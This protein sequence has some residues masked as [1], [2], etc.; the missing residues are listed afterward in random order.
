MTIK[1]F[2]KSKHYSTIP[3]PELEI[4]PMTQFIKDQDKTDLIGVEIGTLHGYNARNIL[5]NLSIKKLYL[6]DPYELYPEYLDITSPFA[7]WAGKVSE[8]KLEPFKDK[9]IRIKKKSEDAVN[10]VPDN[11]DFV[12]ID[13]NHAYLPVLRDLEDYWPKIKKG[14]VFGGHD[15]YNQGEAR[16]VKRAVDEWVAKNKLK[17]YTAEVDWWVIK[18]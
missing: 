14:G 5:D 7:F 12:Y 13:G 11:L 1:G 10:D 2:S 9:I 15:Y 6:I 8:G 18:N 4:R 17:L 16:Q 3:R